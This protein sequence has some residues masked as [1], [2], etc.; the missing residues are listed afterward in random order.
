MKASMSV[1]QGR[2]A[3]AR[4]P[5]QVSVLALFAHGVA[6]RKLHLQPQEPRP[7]ST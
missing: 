4:T 1:S 7:H 3:I 2:Q 5:E 6:G